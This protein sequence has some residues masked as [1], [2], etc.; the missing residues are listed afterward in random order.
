MAHKVDWG[1]V[2]DGGVNPEEKEAHAEVVKPAHPHKPVDPVVPPLTG[3]WE[4][5]PHDGPVVVLYLKG[6]EVTVREWNPRGPKFMML[7]SPALLCNKDTAQG[8]QS[9]LLGAFHAFYCV[10]MA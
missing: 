6:R 1:P 3:F 4:S 10:F 7:L 2:V 5:R 8:T 9:S